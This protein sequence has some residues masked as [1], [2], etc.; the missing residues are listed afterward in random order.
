MGNFWC[1]RVVSEHLLLKR[2]PGGFL[3]LSGSI[4]SE[5]PPVQR[6]MKPALPPLMTAPRS[7]APFINLSTPNL[8]H[9]STANNVLSPDTIIRSVERNIAKT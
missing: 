6:E 2:G 9:R 3:K 4:E 1:L 7:I 8:T 5:W